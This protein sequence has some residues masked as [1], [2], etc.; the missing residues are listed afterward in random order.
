[1]AEAFAATGASVVLGARNADVLESVANR[2]A[3]LGGHAIA[4][5]TDVAD[6][7]PWQRG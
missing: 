3:A 4:V 2:I 1:V 7:S 5:R 6:V